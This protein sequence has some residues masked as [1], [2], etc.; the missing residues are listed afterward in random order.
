[1]PKAI[2]TEYSRYTDQF[3]QLA[4][5]LSYQP[6]MLALEVA[7]KLG[8]HPI[9]LYRWRLEV[10]QKKIK[11]KSSAT[12]L[13]S[14]TDLLKANQRIKALE[15]ELKETK[16]ERDFLKKVKRFSQALKDKSSRS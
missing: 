6:D 3:K 2:S 14:E 7:E 4:V 1:M 8:I 5:L 15:K 13:P 16:Q 9:M 11:G 10:K 12:D